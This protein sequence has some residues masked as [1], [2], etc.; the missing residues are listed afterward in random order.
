MEEGP[1][2]KGGA[3]KGNIVLCGFFLEACQSLFIADL[4]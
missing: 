2:G 3:T 1:A 4:Q